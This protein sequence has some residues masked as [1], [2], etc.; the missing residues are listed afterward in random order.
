M[1][2][3][4]VLLALT[5]V[6][7]LACNSS[8]KSKIVGKWTVDKAYAHRDKYANEKESNKIDSLL[9]KEFAGTVYDFA[10]DGK[11][12]I[13]SATEK[14]QGTWQMAKDE[15]NGNAELS[16][17]LLNGTGWTEQWMPS[18]GESLFY[19]KGIDNAINAKLIPAKNG[20]SFIYSLSKTQ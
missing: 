5:A 8:E 7:I 19:M 3:V 20:T 11:V 14:T 13:T 9:N 16:M 15:K 6:T 17:I 10:A 12:T 4:I 2:I 18:N 1:K